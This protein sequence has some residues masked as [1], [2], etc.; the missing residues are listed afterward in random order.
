[1]AMRTYY[2]TRTCQEPNSTSALAKLISGLKGS[3]GCRCRV[4]T[5]RVS[6]SN[7]WHLS[8]TSGSMTRSTAGR[9][10]RTKPG[11]SPGL[12]RS[13]PLIASQ[14][15]VMRLGMASR[16]FLSVNVRTPSS[17]FALICCW[18]ILLD[19][20]NARAKCPMLYSVYSGSKP[21]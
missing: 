7:R 5:R 18:S 11:Q 16:A 6:G 1:M 14:L 10:A 9:K 19:S 17:T 20:V 12:G 13:P 2:T 4:S 8:S 15:T 21:S 3:N